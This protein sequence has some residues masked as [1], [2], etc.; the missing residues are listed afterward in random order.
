LLGIN[1]LSLSLRHLTD[2]ISR[3]DP[4]TR[5][6]ELLR[7]PLVVEARTII[8]SHIAEGVVPVVAVDEEER[9]VGHKKNPSVWR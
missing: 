6:D 2:V 5:A 8:H 3:A 9:S 1:F 7:N 4:V